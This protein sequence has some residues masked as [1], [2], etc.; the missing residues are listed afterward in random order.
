MK[1]SIPALAAGH[2][3]ETAGVHHALVVLQADQLLD[4]MT[5]QLVCIICKTEVQE[6]MSAT[7]RGDSRMQLTRFNEQLE[8]LFTLLKEVCCLQIRRGG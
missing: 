3:D 4:M 6:D 2:A 5:G 8:P 1:L 7:P